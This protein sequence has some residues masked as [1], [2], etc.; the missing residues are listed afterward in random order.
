MKHS[1]IKTGPTAEP[2]SLT[3]AKIQL[4]IATAD[5]TYDTEVG[6]LLKA[7]RQW[8]ERRYGI[9]LI[10]QSRTQFQDQLYERYPI[11]RNFLG[12]YYSR[13]PVML[14]YPPV[15]S[16]TS[17]KYYDTDQNLQSLTLNT[18]YFAAGLMTPTLG[19]QD[20][21]IPRI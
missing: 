8:V 11:Y 12:P 14:M 4:R 16:I 15:Q 7:A 19:S 17:F 10:T 18:D 5:T 2:V 1:I 3:E 21:E 20:I 6:N 13:F 9:S